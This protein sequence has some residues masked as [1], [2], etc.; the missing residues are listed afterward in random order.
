MHTPPHLSLC[1]CLCLMLLHLLLLQMVPGQPLATPLII[2]AHFADPVRPTTPSEGATPTPRPTPPA[3]GDAKGPVLPKEP[4]FAE[5]PPAGHK[6]ETADNEFGRVVNLTLH[7]TP[8]LPLRDGLEVAAQLATVI[9]Q[10]GSLRLRLLLLPVC[11]K[12]EPSPP[13]T[14]AHL[15]CPLSPCFLHQA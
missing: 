10:D 12:P 14:P 5:P 4:V 11:L 2:A 9:M 3:K 1:L 8:P 6:W 13:H 7:S 15:L